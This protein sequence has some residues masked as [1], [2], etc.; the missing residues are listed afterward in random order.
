M[1]TTE[2]V[3]RLVKDRR[4]VTFSISVRDEIKQKYNGRCAYCGAVLGD[5]FCIDHI[6]PFRDGGIDE[7][8]NLNPACYRCNNR[9][10]VLTVEQFRSEISKQVE[11]L[12]SRSSQYRLAKDYDLVEETFN[13]VRFYFELVQEEKAR[14]DE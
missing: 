11:R 2:A 5:R 10:N 7:I 4:R 6:V 12:N 14:S 13:P 1:S 3:T 9:K 8:E